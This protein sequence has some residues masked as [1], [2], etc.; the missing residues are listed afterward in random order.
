MAAGCAQVDELSTYVDAKPVVA[1]IYN[2]HALPSVA[3]ELP[4]SISHV[5]AALTAAD[6]PPPRIP[7]RLNIEHCVFLI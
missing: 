5:T 2:F 6:R 1:A 7:R 3:L 4:P